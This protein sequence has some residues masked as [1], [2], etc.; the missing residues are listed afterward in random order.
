[1][2]KG[3]LIQAMALMA[4]LMCS[5]SALAQEAY[6][7]FTEADSTLTFYFDELRSTR[8]GTSYS[9]NTGN[10]NPDWLENRLKISQAV[11][12]PH[13]L[14]RAPRPPAVGFTKCISSPPSL[15]SLT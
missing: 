9:M 7:V 2:K 14:M 1:M 15:E 6:A 12:T 4:C 3:F 5:I 13:L 10:N 8:T 11:L